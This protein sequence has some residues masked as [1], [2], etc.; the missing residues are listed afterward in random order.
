MYLGGYHSSGGERPTLETDKFWFSIPESEEA[1]KKDLIEKIQLCSKKR[2]SCT[3]EYRQW[4][5]GPIYTSSQYIV[6]NVELN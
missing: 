6:T 3:I 2:T 5:K 4:F 1:T